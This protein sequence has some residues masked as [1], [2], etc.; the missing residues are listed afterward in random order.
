MLR[1]A[2]RE[3]TRQKSNSFKAVLLLLIMAAFALA[4]IST[5][6]AQQA[7]PQSQAAPG[8]GPGQPGPPD[9][10]KMVPPILTIDRPQA[11]AKTKEPLKVTSATLTADGYIPLINTGYGKNISPQVSWSK[12][13]AGTQSYLL[14]MEDATAG[15]DRKGV[16]HWL[17]FNIPAGV[18]SL[19]E[20]IT[21][22]PDGMLLGAG[23]RG[24]LV[25]Q[26]PHTPAGYTF[27]YA[28][29]IFALDKKLDL[30][31]G[32]SRENVWEAMNGHVL[33]KGD[34]V[35]LFVGPADQP[36]WQPE[37]KK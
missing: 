5:A 32:A 9:M 31:T 26:G 29:Q 2:R 28:I 23:Q 27:H 30:Q 10:S 33:A 4:Q 8:G 25:Y 15:M 35:G 37:Q 3:V 36:A 16:L 24:D 11:D 34:V 20:G 17:A 7:T 1:Q 21:K 22:L 12:G 19:E 14:I 18:T 6:H 13:P